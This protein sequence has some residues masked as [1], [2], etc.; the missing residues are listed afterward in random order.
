M[1]LLHFT[2]GSDDFC[3]PHVFHLVTLCQYARCA[4]A[5]STRSARGVAV[6][7]TSNNS[8][9]DALHHPDHE[10]TKRNPKQQLQNKQAQQ[11]YRYGQA[12]SLACALLS[13]AHRSCPRLLM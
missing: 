8:S 7:A 13:S 11:R 1:A 3:C 6:H 2:C 5:R 9:D 10:K 4:E 12:G